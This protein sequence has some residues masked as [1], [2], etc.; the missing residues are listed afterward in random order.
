MEKLT[1]SLIEGS[2]L[3]LDMSD[4]LLTK[5]DNYISD[6]QLSKPQQKKLIKILE[7]IAGEAY[8]NAITD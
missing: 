8:V 5:I 3:Y 2:S 6:L 4:S 1:N 7:E